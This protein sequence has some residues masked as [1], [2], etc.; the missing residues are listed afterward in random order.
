MTP[1]RGY[2]IV[3]EGPDKAGKTLQMVKTREWIASLGLNFITTR[4]PGGTANGD[5]IRSIIVDLKNKTLLPRAEALLFQ[6]SRAQLV[7]EVIKPALEAGKIVF[8][9][10][11]KES[12]IM[13]QGY[14]RGLDPKAIMA[15]NEFSTEGL[16]A[17]LTVY[18]RISKDELNRR[19]LVDAQKGL[20]ERI[21]LESDN[22][23]E[24]VI[25][26][27]DRLYEEDQ[28]G[29]KKWEIIDAN[30][31]PDEVSNELK[32]KLEARL[33]AAGFLERANLGK[34]R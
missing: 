28:R 25:N 9:D 17:D 7:D 4:E 14:A 13:F 12:S 8:C 24:K 30:K 21:D 19:K 18:F 3:F 33:I 31:P 2:F 16:D 1:R 20:L 27:Y 6:A 32:G 15:L 5:R 29:P 10:R 26:A 23:H 11:Y 22:F 34:E